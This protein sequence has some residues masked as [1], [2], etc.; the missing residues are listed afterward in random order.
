MNLKEKSYKIFLFSDHYKQMVM[1]TLE[2]AIIGKNPSVI[3]SDIDIAGQAFNEKTKYCDYSIIY[4]LL[5]LFYHWIELI[6]KGFL[7]VLTE[8]NPETNKPDINKI[9][10]HDIMILFKQFKNN[11]PDEN[12][13]IDFIG[14]YTIKN[15]MPV[16]L[17]DFFDNNK[18]SVKNY[19]IFFRYPLDKI[20][21][22]TYDYSSITHTDKKGLTFFEDLLKDINR[23]QPLIVKL[24]RKI[25]DQ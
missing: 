17:K 4:P 11:Y 21:N 2:M 20:F 19:Y 9:D 1:N 10:H 15:N 13:I 8:E 12:D 14:K 5:F 25:N 7:L 3:I 16:F 18:L 23:C 22:I 24:G 6:L